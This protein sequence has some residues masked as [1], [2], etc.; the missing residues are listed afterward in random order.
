MVRSV[1]SWSAV[2]IDSNCFIIGSACK[3]AYA[4]AVQESYLSAM[5]TEMMRVVDARRSEMERAKQVRSPQVNGT[6]AREQW[7]SSMAWISSLVGILQ[8]EMMLS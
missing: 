8:A 6:A 1:D 3:V 5:M 2:V 7:E 4:S